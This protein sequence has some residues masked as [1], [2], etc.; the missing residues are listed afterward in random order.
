MANKNISINMVCPLCGNDMFSS[1]EDD[2][3]SD[4][5]DII[6]RCA[7]C[8]SEYSHDELIE[9][10]SELIENTKDEIIDE[11]LADL[12]KQWKRAMKKWTR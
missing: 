2:R 11:A 10:N 5:D 8:K 6:Y 7:E 1:N 12:Q 4:A 9:A 3:S